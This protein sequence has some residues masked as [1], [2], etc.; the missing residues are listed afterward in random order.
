MIPLLR[1]SVLVGAIEQLYKNK[2]LPL[3]VTPRDMKLVKM[4]Q[5]ANKNE[6]RKAGYNRSLNDF[7]PALKPHQTIR[8]IIFHVA[9]L[10]RIYNS[11]RRSLKF[12]SLF[13]SRLGILRVLPIFGR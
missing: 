10:R 5:T 8:I 9:I 12:F 6:S 3:M 4:I 13:E 11:S 2:L 1:N 7:F